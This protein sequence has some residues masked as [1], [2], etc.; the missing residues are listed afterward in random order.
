M[1]SICKG[2]FL[3]VAL[4]LLAQQAHPQELSLPRYLVRF[5]D[6]TL[7][8]LVRLGVDPGDGYGSGDLI[9]F[10]DDTAW[11]ILNSAQ[12]D[13]MLLRG[14]QGTTV[15]E[16]T[17]TLTLIRRALY[18]PR[19]R[20][21][22]PYHTYSTLYSEIDSLRQAAP[23][24]VRTFT[25]GFT[26]AGRLPIRG[27]KLCRNVQKD[28]DRPAILFN[29]CHHSDEIL[30]AE[31]CLRILRA[32][33]EGN[34]T[35]PDITRWLADFQIYIV[36]VINVDG[37][38]VVTSG[39]DPRWRK[40]RRDTDG[41]GVL[42]FGDGIDLNRN[43]D[44]NWAHGG[45]PDPQSE[46]YRG[47]HPFSESENQAF[48]SLAKS[49]RFL[50]SM[51]YHSSG[52]VIYFPWTWKGRKAPDD[53]LLTQIAGGV[54]GSIRTMKGD[55][56]YRAEHGA[57]LVGQ[58]YTWLY[59]ALGTFD[60]VVET[61]RGASFPPAH[62]VDQ[63]VN[64]NLDGVRAFLRQ[65]EGPGIRVRATDKETGAPLEAEVWLPAID[66]EDVRRR[67]TSPG[68][69][70]HYRLLLPGAYNL[71]VTAP[72]YAP[73]ILRGVSVQGSAWTRIDAPLLRQKAK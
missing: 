66:T 24:L 70:V 38:Q 28:D 1:P 42:E 27:V 48:A 62:K 37:Y 26:T 54:A 53:S 56:S 51:T 21:E 25:V 67:S 18:G 6:I 17:D 52:E 36:P 44:F 34:G 30:G 20:L 40:N 46:R 60:L 13:T 65:T 23:D 59:G 22:H 32:F 8:Q 61:G 43:Y 50:A 73:L 4:G 33:I 12:R 72:G 57:G 47:P 71:I 31:I 35:D 5:D 64:A 49:K 45:S 16:S 41:D 63:I 11:T 3:V 14:R 7:D 68:S 69:G 10:V 15:L 2:L 29:G 9:S 39:S 19:L 55:S 58:S